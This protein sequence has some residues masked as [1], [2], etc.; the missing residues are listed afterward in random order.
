[1]ILTGIK[2]PS[3]NNT[4]ESKYLKARKQ[5]QRQFIRQYFRRT[6]R[7]EDQDDINSKI[8]KEIDDRQR[9]HNDCNKPEGI[10][11]ALKDGVTQ[12]GAL[13]KARNEHG[14]LMFLCSSITLARLKYKQNNPMRSLHQVT[15]NSQSTWTLVIR[16]SGLTKTSVPRD[17]RGEQNQA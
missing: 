17:I 11:L 13:E 8:C 4:V 7:F 15:N 3:I 14:T 10:F 2:K 6:Y 12:V 16:K 9:D 5:Q 1:M